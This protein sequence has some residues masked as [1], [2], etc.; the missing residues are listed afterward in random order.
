MTWP[1]ANRVTRRILQQYS[2]GTAIKRYAEGVQVINGE[3]MKAV[4]YE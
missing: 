1:R 4:V 2:Y 3:G